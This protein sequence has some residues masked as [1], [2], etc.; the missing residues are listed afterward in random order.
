MKDRLF[1]AALYIDAAPH[2][3]RKAVVDT[4]DKV[5]ENKYEIARLGAT[6]LVVGVAARV[7]GFKAGYE[8]AQQS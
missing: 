1:I 3:A 5:I 7:A 2:L 8:F 6:A 4:K